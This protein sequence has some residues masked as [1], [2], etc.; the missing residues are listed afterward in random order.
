MNSKVLSELQS[1]SQAMQSLVA[2]SAHQ[3]R[4]ISKDISSLRDHIVSIQLRVDFSLVAISKSLQVLQTLIG[5]TARKME[6][7]ESLVRSPGPS[8]RD[9]E[10][11]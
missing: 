4:D 9:W 8:D 7:V 1:L 11:I 6:I 3:E 10:T 5:D 2:R